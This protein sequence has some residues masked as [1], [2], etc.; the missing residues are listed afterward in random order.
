VESTTRRL[1]AFVALAE[2]G[3]FGR[4]AQTTFVSQQAL[5]KQIATLEA[6]VGAAL[7]RRTSRSVELTPAGE[8]FLAACRDAL[9]IIDDA[10]DGLRG[11][12]GFMR[13]GLV[14][15]GALELTEP[16]LETFRARRPGCEVV[17][18]QF[19]FEDPS[20]GLADGASDV[21]VVRL[22]ITLP[23]MRTQ[24]LFA[25]PRVAAVAITHRLARAASISVQALRDERM[26]TSTATD[27]AYRRFWTLLDQLPGTK[28]P[29]IPVRSH[30]EE[31]E[32]V[33][34]G[35]AISVTS[36]CAAR[37]TPHPGVRFV[38]LTDVPATVC[39]LAWRA[40]DE[41]AAVREFVDGATAVLRHEA[42][43]L[44]AIEQPR[45]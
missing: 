36:A 39:A 45:W 30:A 15:L 35:R 32:V 21:S 27:E 1:R 29:P 13:V 17:L 40:E 5:S 22:P 34:S 41:T 11:D 18:R 26:T 28:H 31:L 2:H 33:A 38:P 44:H 42:G 14:V 10:V 20:A 25:E 4:A 23:G 43:L 7:V 8:T 19:P 3:H 6:E 24:P 9:R 16:I 12:P 37:L